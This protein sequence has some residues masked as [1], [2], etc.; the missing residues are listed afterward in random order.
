MSG[1]VPSGDF[2]KQK[3]EQ[4][5]DKSSSPGNVLITEVIM[6]SIHIDLVCMSTYRLFVE[7]DKMDLKLTGDVKSQKIV[8]ENGKTVH[9][10]ET[11][12]S[13]KFRL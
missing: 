11:H 7:F 12:S 4:T 6:D 3:A 5:P 9:L 13:L 8:T 10:Y 1:F 2:S